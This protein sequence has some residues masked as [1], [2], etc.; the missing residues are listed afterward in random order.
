MEPMEADR[1]L[2]KSADA[3][4]ARILDLAEDAIISIDADQR[5]MLFN[6]GAERIFGYRPE[7][8]LGQSLSILLP[9]SSAGV[10]RQH[11]HEFAASPVTA[12]TMGERREI[13][14]RRK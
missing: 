9:A 8:I 10:H 12:C 3:L 4:F 5:I 11:I 7:E 14:G 2:L 13:F 1:I 6:Q